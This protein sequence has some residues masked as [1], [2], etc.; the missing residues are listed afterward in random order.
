MTAKAIVSID[1]IDLVCLTIS[2][3][4]AL[5]EHA[6]GSAI[7]IVHGDRKGHRLDNRNDVHWR[8]SRRLRRR[9]LRRKNAPCYANLNTDGSQGP[10]DAIYGRF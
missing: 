4:H 3:G 7:A 10:P 5:I 6:F 1:L 8:A 9:L 2:L